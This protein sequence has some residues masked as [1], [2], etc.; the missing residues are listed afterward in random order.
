MNY[1]SILTKM[2]AVLEQ[3]VKYYLQTEHEII[4]LNDIL[5][6]LLELKFTGD[7]FC[8][9]CGRKTSKSFGQGYCY[10]CFITIP[11]TEECVLRPEL[12][13]AHL[14]IA[15]NL[16]YARENCLQDHFVYLASSAEIKVGV[17]RKSQIPTRWIDQG[18]N[19]AVNIALTP[20][21][22]KAG[23]IEVEL[24]KHIL[25]KTNWRSMLVNKIAMN[26]DFD[27]A[28][29]IVQSVLPENLKQYLINEIIITS[30]DYPVIQY[31]AKVQSVDLAKEN[32]IKGKLIGIKGQYLIFEN[33]NVINLRK[34]TGYKVNIN[35]NAG[36]N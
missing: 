6:Y 17:T 30:I 8:I 18:A 33:S 7:I 14:G 5:G 31:P 16:D 35:V 3:P 27:K 29:L 10:P 13:K 28:L 4:K 32:I 22:F 20:N 36:S 34:Y 25:D 19:F 1:I 24:K 26:P 23:L 15:R 11:Q 12:C 21:R 2:N 9:N